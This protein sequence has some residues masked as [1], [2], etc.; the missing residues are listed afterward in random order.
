VKVELSGEARA[1]VERADAWW[2]ENRPAAPD[3]FANE[4]DQALVALE[5]AP[6]LGLRY[7][8]KPGIRRLLLQRTSYHL[9]FLV[10]ADR[11]YVVAVWSAYRGRG[12]AL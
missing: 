7:E 12:P 11:V 3:L 4:L 10:Q 2:R 5:G 9:Y 8:L 1:E 6:G